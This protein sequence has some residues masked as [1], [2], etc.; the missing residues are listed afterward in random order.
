MPE[1]IQRYL[2]AYRNKVTNRLWGVVRLPAQ[3][4]RRG[5]VLLS[6]LTEPFT[7]TP[8]EGLSNFHSNYWECFEIAR[9]F[10]E[11]GFSVDIIDHT[12]R[13]FVPK[14]RYAAALDVGANLERLSASL[15]GECEKIFFITS[16]HWKTQN[17][18]EQKRLD[19]LERRRGVRLALRRTLE[20][21]RSAEAADFLLALGGK[22]NRESYAFIGKPIF[23]IPVS[24]ALEFDF[25]L[26]K[27]MDR[28][29]RR[30]LWLGGGGA[31]LKGLDLIL[32]AFSALP[33]YELFVCGPVAAERDFF[34]LYRQELC[35]T[36]NIHYEGRIDI[37]GERFKKLL[38][39]C[40]AVIHASAS[41]GGGGAAIQ[42]MQAGLIPI[43]TYE[44]TVPTEGFGIR[45]PDASVASIQRAAREL[46][47]LP[48]SELERR[49][50]A[51]WEYARREHSREAFS[52]A[53]D[54]F[55][56]KELGL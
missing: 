20:E 30:F 3:G 1:S 2:L 40:A 36:A 7:R 29:R 12:N 38:V 23:P 49:S 50:K 39:E 25:P 21:N 27:D 5:H 32:E 26:N 33:D 47:S 22:F 55:M 28:A 11:R 34:D 6:Y 35:Q 17:Q 31:V 53:V 41:E 19:D 54:R 52:R 15:G 45:L 56:T 24:A 9:L 42:A 37:G 48:I 14:K 44:S 4:H 8:R 13:T 46:A 16:A 18:A 43:A 51:T 10:S